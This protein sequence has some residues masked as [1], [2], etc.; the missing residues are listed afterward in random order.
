MKRAKILITG[1]AGFIGSWLALEQ[2]KRGASPL[3]LDNLSS[4]RE[5]NLNFLNHSDLIL[6]DVCL[7]KDLDKIPWSEITACFHLAARGNVHESILDPELHLNINTVGSF[8]VL[9][10][11][12]EHRVPFLLTSTCMVYGLKSI[13]KQDRSR[14]ISEHHPAIPVSPYASSKLAAEHLAIG[15]HFTY[16]LKIRI[17]RP[18]NT[19]GPHQAHDN[20]EGGVIPI[21]LHRLL[22]RQPLK[23]SGDGS[24]TRDFLYVKDCAR[25]LS[26]YMEGEDVPLILNAGSGKDIS[27]LSLAEKIAKGRVPVEFQTHPHSQSEIQIL[28]C[29][30]DLAKKTIGFEPRFDL[31]Q[32]LNENARWLEETSKS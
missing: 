17:A 15:Y 24:Q 9:E 4:G 14:G 5:S 13:S 28:L 27:I 31:E 16:D 11:C 3:L 8:R 12:K 18:F 22:K 2:E 20:S 25:F 7:P 1:G 19:Y 26:D 32:G 29:D 10:K 23:I 21:F 30:N 6:G